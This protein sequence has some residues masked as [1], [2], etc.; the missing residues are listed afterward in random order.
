M[1]NILSTL[2]VLSSIFLFTACSEL[3]KAAQET[4]EAANNIKAEAD[5]KI[6]QVKQATDSTQKAI[7]AVS[8]AQNDIKAIGE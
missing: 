5:E 6:N 2:L 7:E 4:T 3:S 8:Q 1:K